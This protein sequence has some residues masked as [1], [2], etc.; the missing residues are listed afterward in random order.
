MGQ[1]LLSKKKMDDEPREKITVKPVDVDEIDGTKSVLCETIT[2]AG[3]LTITVPIKDESKDDKLQLLEKVYN[4]SSSIAGAGSDFFHKYRLFRDKEMERIELM[5]DQYHDDVK[6]A[7]FQNDRIESMLKDQATSQSRRDKRKR[8]KE[9][10]KLMKE[11]K[12]ILKSDTLDSDKQEFKLDQKS[13]I[14]A[15]KE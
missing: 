3:G 8:K 4:P 13:D 15:T 9:K 1:I 11:A 6:Q 14:S 7:R 10:L 2:L 12:K 5:D